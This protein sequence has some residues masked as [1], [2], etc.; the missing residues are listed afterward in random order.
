[1]CFNFFASCLSCVVQILYGPFFCRANV[2][3]GNIHSD[4]TWPARSDSLEDLCQYYCSV[5][6]CTN[7]FCLEFALCLLAKARH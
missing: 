5:R 4:F 3:F 6:F 7:T 2:V 1:M